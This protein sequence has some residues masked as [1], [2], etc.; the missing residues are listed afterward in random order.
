MTAEH[1]QG[2]GHEGQDGDGADDLDGPGL[3]VV[4][5]EARQAGE[6][7]FFGAHGGEVGWAEEEEKRRR[8][9]KK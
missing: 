4:L 5:V 3:D 6:L 7:G 2:D 1:A 9:R 8:R